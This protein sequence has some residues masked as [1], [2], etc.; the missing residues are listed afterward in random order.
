MRHGFKSWAEKQAAHYRSQLSL[1]AYDPLR[2]RALAAFLGVPILEPS[3]IPGVDPVA[4]SALL[5]A[6]E[7]SAVC[8]PRGNGHI[9]IYHPRHSLARQES[10]LM[11]E[12]AHIIC[13]HRPIQLTRN[14]CEPSKES[15][16]EEE[17]AWLGAVLQ[18]PRTALQW[19]LRRQMTSADM[20]EHFGASA[21][22]ITYRR[23]VTGVDVQC[24]RAQSRH[25]LR[26]VKN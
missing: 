8:I 5:D 2:A 18:V 4:I 10:D 17:A 21:E 14:L 9:V 22:M 7:W 16:Q 11:H 1:R 20:V 12:L 23:R 24:K 13:E 6:R 26:I 3:E 19:A 25:Q 15:C